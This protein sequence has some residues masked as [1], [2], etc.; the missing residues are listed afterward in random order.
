MKMWVAGKIQRIRVTDKSLNYNGSVSIDAKLMGLAG[1]EAYEQVDIVN[2]SNGARWTTYAIPAEQGVFSLN[3]GGAR[4]G[5]IGDRCVIMTYKMAEKFEPAPV[6]YIRSDT[7]NNEV[8]RRF[9]YEQDKPIA[10]KDQVLET[11]EA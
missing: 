3:G 9:Y 10:A 2:L 7:A 11:I 5:E 6:V 8:D 1:I 4:L